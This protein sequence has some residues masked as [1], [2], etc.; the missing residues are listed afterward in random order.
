MGAL[1][2]PE[3]IQFSAWASDMSHKKR[4]VFIINSLTVG[5]AER[6]MCTFLASSASERA[7]FEISLVLLDIEESP[8]Q[9]ADWVEVH[10]LDSRGSL[11]RG[12][13]ALLS[14]FRRLH[15][16]VSISFLTRAN[17][18][19]V[20][21]SAFWRIPC[22]ISERINT[23]THFRD[24][25]TGRL[26][27]VLVKAIYPR[28]TRVIAVSA[29]VAQDLQSVFSV[30]EKK[31][32]VIANP[33]DIPSI[34]AQSH[35]QAA[36]E[37]DD[38]AYV[39]SM[40]RLVKSKN[41]AL[42][43]EAFAQSG[44]PGKLVILGEGPEREALLRKA[45]DL[46]L[47]DRVLFPGFAKNPF[48]LLRRAGVFVLSSSAEGF[49][50]SLLEAM[51]VGIPVISTNCASGPSEILADCSR[52]EIDGLWFAEYGI[53]VP[54]DS[55]ELMAK[56]LHAMTDSDLRLRYGKKAAERARYFTVEKAKRG[57][58]EVVRAELQSA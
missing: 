13:V 55:A 30:P 20:L 9:L 39:M 16:D 57:Y 33:I 29:G 37:L 45:C 34:Q 6:V 38:E 53:L 2:R 49:P 7:D 1:I 41:F 8:Y 54:T 28:A 11:L 14:L 21:V 3:I 27:K 50:N 36:I 58:W 46:G 24:D 52:A 42:L 48:A 15:P 10:Q 22:I 26:A 40:G 5:G 35:E 17:L 4:A 56:A 43:I 19:N 47:R 23:S 44:F 31:L 51:A 32:V 18:A 12:I 25:W